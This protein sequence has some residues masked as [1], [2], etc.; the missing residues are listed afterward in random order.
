[1]IEPKKNTNLFATEDTLIIRGVQEANNGVYQCT[2]TNQVGQGVS[3][4]Q[5][6]NVK[7]TTA[8]YVIKS[9]S[10]TQSPI[11][12]PS[13]ANADLHT[14][15]EVERHQATQLNCQYH[16]SSSGSLEFRWSMNSSKDYVDI[17]KSQYT[18][19]ADKSVLTFSAKTDMDF[20]TYTCQASDAVGQA[21]KPC[22]FQIIPK[23]MAKKLVK[24]ASLQQKTSLK[25]H[26]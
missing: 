8:A 24:K 9:R 17:A 20:G 5:T 25:S 23:G 19:Q 22:T 21:S 2:A 11:A 16:S 13:C 6:V 26:L 18:T 7:G 4:S 14:V 3:N 15:V 10:I 1:M 12:F